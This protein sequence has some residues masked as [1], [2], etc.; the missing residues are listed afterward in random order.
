[1]NPEPA[2]SISSLPLRPGDVVRLQIFREPDM[3]GDFAVDEAGIVVLPRLGP[4]SVTSEPADSLRAALTRQYLAFLNHPS[5]T[6]TLLRRIQVLGAVRSPGLYPMDATM[7][8]GDALA[9][10]GGTTSQ[11]NPRRLELFRGGE[12]VRVDLSPETPISTS[13]IRSGDQIYVPERS[14]LSRNTWLV[15]SA[16][17]A[18]VSIAIAVIRYR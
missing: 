12:K 5:V 11:G 18:S 4:V 10:A 14:W 16:F 1:M 7:T 15:S 17:G 2:Q 13:P 6:V 8:V 3:S 9:L